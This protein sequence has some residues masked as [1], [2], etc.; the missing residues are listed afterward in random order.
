MRVKYDNALHIP[1]IRTEKIFHVTRIA[2]GERNEERKILNISKIF[3]MNKTFAEIKNVK[4]RRDT[5]V[6]QILNCK[7]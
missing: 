7:L 4:D 2:Q 6:S 5:I 1:S 3:N